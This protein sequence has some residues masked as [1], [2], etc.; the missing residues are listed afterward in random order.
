MVKYVDYRPLEVSVFNVSVL[1]PSSQQGGVDNLNRLPFHRQALLP[2][3]SPSTLIPTPSPVSTPEK[4]VCK[5]MR[6]KDELK[7]SNLPLINHKNTAYLISYF[8]SEGNSMR[9]G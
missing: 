6:L 9:K 4:E 8:E 2:R 7:A 3:L 5:Q 1:T